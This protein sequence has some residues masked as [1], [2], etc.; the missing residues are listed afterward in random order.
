M[1]TMMMIKPRT[2]DAP[3]KWPTSMAS[4]VGEEKEEEVEVDMNEEEP[5]EWMA[6]PDGAP[7]GTRFPIWLMVLSGVA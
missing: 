2:S 3:R 5:M 6:T 1:V 4:R 7:G